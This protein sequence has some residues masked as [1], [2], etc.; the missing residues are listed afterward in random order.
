[1]VMTG[2]LTEA[3]TKLLVFMVAAIW[4]ANET[5]VGIGEGAVQEL[6]PPAPHAMFATWVPLTVTI[7][8]PPSHLGE[9]PAGKNFDLSDP[10]TVMVPLPGIPELAV[11]SSTSIIWPKPSIHRWR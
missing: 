6:P 11:G 8:N 2:P 3:C 4:L 1:M 7:R 9:Q 5:A 10:A